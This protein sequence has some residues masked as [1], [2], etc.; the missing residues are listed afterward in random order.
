MRNFSMKP[1]LGL[2]VWILFSLTA[3]APLAPA[4]TTPP[5][6][7]TAAPAP[8]AAS[9][10]PTAAASSTTSTAAQAVPASAGSAGI[11]FVVDPSKSEAS[12]SVRE[13][14]AKFSLPND[15]IGKTN[16]IAGSITLKPDGSLDP[17]NSKIT[18]DL[19]TLKTDESMRDNY[20]RQNILQTGQYP[21]AVFVPTLIS[22]LPG[23]IPQSGS[24]SF[25][26]TGDLTIHSVTKPVTWDVTGSVNN[27][28][29]TGTATTSFTFEDFGLNQPRVSIVLSVVDKITLSVNVTFTRSN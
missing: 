22:G 8:T 19:S 6:T 29:A 17:A 20:V 11:K 21:Q 10:V 1:V 5:A 23:A 9:A 28:V 13:Q 25:K 7:A 26:V 2:V 4:A 18:V 3:C 27:G 15:A 16:A 24:V 12:Y 14:L